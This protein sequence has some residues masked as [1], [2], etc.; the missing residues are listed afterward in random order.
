[1]PKLENIEINNYTTS[2]G[3]VYEKLQ[4][5]YET[6]GSSDS[7]APVVV[8]FHALT[9]N[10]D[11][12]SAEKGWW[13][14]LIGYNKCID[15]K[16]YQVIAFNILGNGYDG[17]TIKQYKDFRAV[18][19]AKLGYTCLQ[20][21]GI[22]SIHTVIGGSLGGGIA[23]EFAA[24]YPNY[25]KQL[26]AVACDWKSTDWLMGICGT[27]ERTLLNSSKPIE[28]AR[29]VAMLFYRSPQSLHSKFNRKWQAGQENK[30]RQINS[31]LDHHGNKLADRFSKAAYLMMNHLLSTIDICTSRGFQEIFKE[32]K[33]RIIQ[34]GIDSDLL[35][36]CYDNHKTKDQLDDLG[37]DNQY[38]EI[39]SD[40]GHDAFLIEHQQLTQFLKPYFSCKS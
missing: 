29:Q 15:T 19:I 21:R 11:V 13:S 20:A 33:I 5:S 31:W 36:P 16:D 37:I 35:F 26:V 6:F 38:F 22:K 23:W 32:S 27:Q 34:V 40:H 39:Q 1:M 18:D 8:V 30:L 14:D 3:A 4:V 12:C 10:S 9:G 17:T 25:V 2:T 7:G 24:L 28:D